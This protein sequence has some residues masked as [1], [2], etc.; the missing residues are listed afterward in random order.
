MTTRSHRETIRT[1]EELDEEAK[2][3]KG[4]KLVQM[5]ATY[6]VIFENPGPIGVARTTRW[7]IPR[8]VFMQAKRSMGVMP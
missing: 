5:G 2:K 7:R 1:L 6:Y 4:G 3:W 8:S